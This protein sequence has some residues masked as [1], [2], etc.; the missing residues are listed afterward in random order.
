MTRAA[1]SWFDDAREVTTRE[2]AEALWM[3]LGRQTLGPCPACEAERRG[4]ADPRL[5]LLA[6]RGG[7]SCVRCSAHGGP[8]ELVAR[9]VA[10]WDGE[11][12]P[13]G[14]HWRIVRAWYAEHDWCDPDGA[15]AGTTVRR[16]PR[17]ARVEPRRLPVP[18]DLA[19]LWAACPPVIDPA[20]DLWRPLLGDRAEGD[21]AA[22]LRARGL[23]PAL[24]A[25][26]DLA[27]ALPWLPETPP[28]LRMYGASQYVNTRQTRMWSRAMPD[29]K[30]PPWCEEVRE[31]RELPAGFSWYELGY[32]LAVPLYDAAGRLASLHGRCV[33]LPAERP[34][35]LYL[36]PA[37]R[38]A[39]DV[40]KPWKGRAP[41]GFAVAGLVMADALGRELLTTGRRPAWWPAEVPFRVVVAEGEPDFLTWATRWADS[42]EDAPAVL[43]VVAGSW[44]AELAARIPDGARVIVRT[45]ADKDGDKYAANI[46]A[47]LAGRCEVRR[48]RRDGGA[49]RA[50]G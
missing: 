23:D 8:L 50:D 20:A 10:K 41:A 13:S 12:K 32:R 28:G 43:G 16:E 18:E 45:H 21:V 1:R 14:E 7:W 42:A 47:T 39:L 40:V 37:D 27:R 22:W 34:A 26:R 5:P 49:T 11:D 15:A 2:V 9:V 46:R 17:P 24:V 48:P 30:N 25:E 44:T 6:G 33:T 36:V 19:A 29:P 4:S 3:T 35:P 31:C 38:P